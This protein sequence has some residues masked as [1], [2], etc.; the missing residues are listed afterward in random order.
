[1]VTVG[2]EVSASGKRR[3]LPGFKVKTVLPGDAVKL[4]PHRPRFIEHRQLDAELFKPFFTAADALEDKPPGAPRQMASIWVVTC[5][6][7]Q[8]R[9]GMLNLSITPY[10]VSSTR[11]RFSTSSVTGLTPI[12]ASPA[13]KESPS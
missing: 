3:A 10:T 5:A 9:V 11:L 7:T 6:S 2:A 8:P 4:R 13:P 12:T 1:M